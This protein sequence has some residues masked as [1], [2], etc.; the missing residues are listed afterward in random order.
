MVCM[1]EMSGTLRKQLEKKSNKI[2][3]QSFYYKSLIFEG[4]R[5][6]IFEK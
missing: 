6:I 4:V 1:K 3:L 2:Y 5:A